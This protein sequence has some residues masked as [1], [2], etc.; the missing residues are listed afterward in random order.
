MDAA[1]VKHTAI[2][3]EKTMGRLKRNR[4]LTIVRATKHSAK[5]HTVARMFASVSAG[6]PPNCHANAAA[7]KQNTPTEKPAARK[8]SQYVRLN[9][10][11]SKWRDCMNPSTGSTP[12]VGLDWRK[13]TV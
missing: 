1:T 6:R 2:A 9:P 3:P 4:Q 10:C 8:R 13:P 12:H 7:K 11:T 5:D